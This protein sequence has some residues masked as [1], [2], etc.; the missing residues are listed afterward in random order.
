[1]GG[2]V[3]VF[4]GVKQE[5]LEYIRAVQAMNVVQPGGGGER[6]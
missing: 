3:C 1:M 5:M 2:Y 4:W 6:E